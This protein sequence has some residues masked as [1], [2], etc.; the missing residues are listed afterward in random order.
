MR[1]SQYDKVKKYKKNRIGLITTKNIVLLTIIVATFVSV[2][3]SYWNSTL[4]ITGVA[5]INGNSGGGG[6][7]NGGTWSNPVI[8]SSTTTYDPS[9]IQEGT[10]KFESVPGQPQVTADRS[11]KIT[12]FEYMNTGTGIAI[13][14]GGV[15][16]GVL[17]FDGSDFDIS[18]TANFSLSN[19][20]TSQTNPVIDLS[21]A[22]SNGANGFL[23]FMASNYG[24]TTYNESGTAL[25]SSSSNRY[26][27]FRFNKYVNGS[28]VSNECA[29]YYHKDG[30]RQFYTARFGT[31]TEPITLTINVKCRSGV[32]S[33]EIIYND[34]VI[35]KPRYSSA[36]DETTFTYSDPIG[37]ATIELGT[38]Q[39]ND[40][41]A[42]TSVFDVIAFSVQKL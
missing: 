10:T 12:R 39:K 29:D 38:W 27:K 28:F 16:T 32:Y 18:L 23:V 37:N 24:G 14:T 11:G 35:A 6:G 25:S 1:K 7:N 34:T 13:P 20:D 30:T 8:D 22:D 17:A 19:V 26:L 4:H 31:R 5:K 21:I 2:G 40:Q 36:G 15:D 41:T 3:Y 42:Y 33:S 9:N